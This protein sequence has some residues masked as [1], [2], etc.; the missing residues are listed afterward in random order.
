MPVDIRGRISQSTIAADLISAALN[1]SFVANSGYIKTTGFAIFKGRVTVSIGADITFVVEPPTGGAKY[2]IPRNVKCISHRYNPV[3]RTTRVELG[4]NFAIAEGFAEEIV[5]EPKDDPTNENFVDDGSGIPTTPFKAESIVGFCMD[6]LQFTDSNNFIPDYINQQYSRPEFDFSSGYVQILGDM[7]LSHGLLGI[8]GYGRKIK[9]VPINDII[10]GVNASK[11]LTSSSIINLEP[12]GAGVPP[13]SINVS[14]DTV[15]LKEPD[16]ENAKK[17]NWETEEVFG[18][19]TTVRISYKEG[20]TLWEST[21]EYVPYQKI[22]RKYDAWDRLERSVTVSR[23]IGAAVAASY[24][25]AL[26]KDDFDKDSLV[27]G[28]RS[29]AF[30]NIIFDTTDVTDIKYVKD[31]PV[32][33]A[34]QSSFTPA[35]GYEEVLSEVKRTYKAS[36][37]VLASVAPGWFDEEGNLFVYEGFNVFEGIFSDDI[38]NDAAIGGTLTEITETTYEQSKRGVTVITESVKDEDGDESYRYLRL[39]YFPVTKTITKTAKCYGLT[40]RGQQDIATRVDQGESLENFASDILGLADAGTEVRIVSGREA[41]LQAR[42]RATERLLA[43]TADMGSGS[44]A[45]NGYSVVQET[46]DLLVEGE[47][48]SLGKYPLKLRIP[49]VSDDIFIRVG[50]PPDETY[51]A[52]PAAPPP[53]TT[54]Q[55]FGRNQGK[56]IIGGQLGLSVQCKGNALNSDPVGLVTVMLSGS[57][58]NYLQNGVTYTISNEGVIASVELIALGSGG[59]SLAWLPKPDAISLPP[60]PTVTSTA[61]TTVLGEIATVGATPQTALNAAYPSAVSGNGVFAQDTSFYWVYNGTLWVNVG[62]TPGEVI[63]NPVIVPMYEEI[64]ALRGTT[65][66]RVEVTR[67]AYALYLLTVLPPISIK[68]KVVA[69]RIR[70]VEVPAAAPVTLAAQIPA[71]S[72]GAKV[73]PPV[74]DVTLAALPPGISVGSSISVPSGDF[75]VTAL[76]PEVLGTAST[77]VLV[78]AADIAV[79]ASTP[80]ISA[81]ASVSVPAL[82]TTVAAQTPAVTIVTTDPNF[83][84][85]SLLLHLDG[86]DASTTFTDSSSNA[87]TITRGGN[88]ELDTAITK[89]GTAAVIWDGTGDF[90]RTPSDVDFTFGTGDFTI[91]FWSYFSSSFNTGLAAILMSVGA[92]RNITYTAS[93]LRFRSDGGTNLITG[94]AL[95]LS[96]WHHIALTKSGNDHKLFINGTQTGSTY[97]N[98]TSYTADRITFGANN[99]GGNNYLGSMDE[100]RVTTGVARYT[101]NFTAPTQAF[102]D[103]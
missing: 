92:F 37:E 8:A 7:L 13:S 1:D 96:T 12:S 82:D 63:A 11:A 38:P 103:S 10:N 40:S 62:P 69:T 34:N 26:I 9:G 16:L 41:V 83:A 85:V 68:V 18:L 52:Y 19:P 93:T 98:S 46:E 20:D 27:K 22:W 58:A 97:T 71:V 91:E 56:L 79:A 4:C 15:R 35:E 32:A 55:N 100:I 31:A 80:A 30:G 5:W 57:S 77:D 39:G 2:A 101:A 17:R 90:L 28:A 72:T 50:T 23:S 65:R 47:N 6:K 76:V 51:E 43:D 84:S 25:Q 54:A 42:P 66:S 88:A 78:P 60:L 36:M 89:F 33:A 67:I 44:A 53:E 95:S 87:F 49:Y 74:T 24:C 29:I 70:K 59:G 81:G 3:E 102:P 61:P 21:F 99:T 64:V 94:G 75:S 86:T 14:Y 73:A 48:P 45:T